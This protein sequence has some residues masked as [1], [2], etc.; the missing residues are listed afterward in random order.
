M[1]LSN[2]MKK[3]VHDTKWTD[4]NGD[5]KQTDNWNNPISRRRRMQTLRDQKEINVTLPTTPWE[6]K[7]K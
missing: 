3:L 6:E 1:K 7:D 5:A 4:N 2:D